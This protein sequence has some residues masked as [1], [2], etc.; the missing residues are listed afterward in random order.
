MGSGWVLAR[1]PDNSVRASCVATQVNYGTDMSTFV[2]TPTV[3]GLRIL[4]LRALQRDWKVRTADISVAFLHSKTQATSTYLYDR[5]L[6]K[7]PN[8]AMPKENSFGNLKEPCMV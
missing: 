1:K 6:R 8:M 3:V 4:L 7:I 5:L 2:A